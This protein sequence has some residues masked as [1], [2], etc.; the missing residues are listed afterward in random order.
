MKKALIVWMFLVA[1]IAISFISYVSYT[2]PEA[3]DATQEASTPIAEAS[4]GCQHL[5]LV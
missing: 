1:V 4:I 5:E 2:T 3:S